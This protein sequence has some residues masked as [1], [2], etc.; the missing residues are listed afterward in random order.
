MLDVGVP[1]QGFGLALTSIVLSSGR[2]LELSELRQSSTY[3]GMLEGY[4]CKR[5]NDGLVNG[6][7]QAAERAFPATPVH[8]V[9][10]AL[11]YQDQTAGAFGP[12]EVLPAV[13]RIGAFHFSA[14]D[15]EHDPAPWRP[16]VVWLQ[17][18]PDIP[19]SNDSADPAPL[20]H[21]LGGV[22][23]RPRAVGARRPMRIHR[24]RI[25]GRSTDGPF[26]SLVSRV[27]GPAE[28]FL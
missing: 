24:W 25:A 18:A 17:P 20:R 4:P 1:V 22:G 28:G 16:T 9:P 6:L 8:L 26:C 11:E 15:P 7:L 3:G 10:P 5:V 14:L 2:S 21:P 12:V 23:A 27:A 19:S 13:A